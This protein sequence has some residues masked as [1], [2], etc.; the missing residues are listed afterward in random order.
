[1]L[2]K[3]KRD[4]PTLARHPPK[5]FSLTSSSQ[6]G[7]TLVQQNIQLALWPLSDNTLALLLCNVLGQN[8]WAHLAPPR[9]RVLPLSGP[10]GLPPSGA[11]DHQFEA[12][13]EI[14]LARWC[15]LPEIYHQLQRSVL[16][17]ASLYC[18]SQGPQAVGR[19]MGT[20]WWSKWEH[21][22]NRRQQFLYRKENFISQNF[23]T[24]KA[25]TWWALLVVEKR[26]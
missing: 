15:Q 14:Q 10:Q 12:V 24:K 16:V 5:A 23:E 6:S 4:K 8:L 20:L 9:L 26:A 2:N 18:V 3:V 11:R 17:S 19:L 7:A 21:I 25:E 1:M 13:W 22:C